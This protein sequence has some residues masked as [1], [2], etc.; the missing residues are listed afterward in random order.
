MTVV[1][2]KV[3]A[4][5]L[6]P[7]GVGLLGLYQS[8]MSSVASVS[9]MGI[10]SSGVQ[11]VAAANGDEAKMANALCALRLVGIGLGTIGALILFFLRNQVSVW[12]FGN[13]DHMAALAVLSLC[14][15]CTIIYQSQM[16]IFNGLRRLGDMA[17][18]NVIGSG[19]GTIAAI[20]LIWSLGEAAV[21]YSI[22]ASILIMLVCSSW[23]LRGIARPSPKASRSGAGIEILS[24][25]GLGSAFM[26]AGLMMAGALLF[27]RVIFLRQLGLD[28]VG[29]FQ[30]A[31]GVA[32]SYV[33]FILAAMSVD[34]YP[35][36]TDCIRKDR[37]T[38]HRL[39]NEQ[40]EVALVLGG[41]LIM[42]MLMFSDLLIRVFYSAQF[43]AAPEVLR[44]L[45]LGSIVKTVSWPLGYLI[46]ANSWAKI[47]I[48][49]ELVWASSYASLVYLGCPYFGINSAGY[50]FAGSYLVLVVVLYC[51]AQRC[52]GF[53][54]SKTNSRLIA[55]MVI[56]G[57]V[58]A[59]LASRG[60]FGGYLGGG[61][62]TSAFSIVC[63]KRAYRMID[64]VRPIRMIH[65][66]RKTL[67]LVPHPWGYGG[68]MKK[69]DQGPRWLSGK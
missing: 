35:R 23:F 14:V 18:V 38:G 15:L 22:V 59:L 64:D 53:A 28:A 66:I 20:V 11:Q 47:T 55:A 5:C 34:F 24:L 62:M 52:A 16:A 33:D 4:I 26:V 61:V 51:T 1:R 41:P 39:V 9:G 68:S 29:Q 30:A 69:A 3:F 56:G 49:T 63:L 43:A 37:L 25:L 7:S 54:W 65:S 46:M 57:I 8:V 36:L 12:T 44:W 58:V 13:D 32:F 67:A 21:V 50:A 17:R 6:G 48:F 45:L 10:A 42:G 60:D 19:G 40:T 31:W 27:T 2:M